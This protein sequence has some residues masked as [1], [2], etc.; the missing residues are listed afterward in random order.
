MRLL[1]SAGEASGERYGAQLIEALR[2]R[3]PDLQ[4]FGVGGESMQA[5]GCDLIVQSKE[6]AV[7]G[8]TEILPRLPKIYGEFRKLVRAVDERKPQAAILIDS[9]A[10]HFKVARELHRRGIP[11]IYYVAPQLWAWRSGRVRLMRR[12]FKKAL[13]IFPF[14]EQWYRQRG[15]D[16]EFVGHPLADLQLPRISRIEFAGQYGL[17]PTRDWIALLPGSRRK[18]VRMN[19]GTM[20]K[21]ALSLQAPEALQRPFHYLIERI[22]AFAVRQLETIMAG[23]DALGVD[24]GIEQAERLWRAAPAKPEYEFL[25]PVASTLDFDWVR[26]ILGPTLVPIRL[27]RDS[28][29]TLA[30]ACAA[31]VASG[32]ATVEAAMMGTPMAVVYRVSPLTWTLGRPLVHVKNFAMVNL[33]AGKQVV[34]ELIQSD[35]TPE[36]VAAKL[37]EILPD[38]PAREKMEQDL[39]Q[40]RERLKCGR[41]SRTAA[42]RAADAVLR[43]L[44]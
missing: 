39:A 15:V 38:G 40:V 21:G 33:I 43:S 5:A 14:E 8:I 29:T 17:N 42:E 44:N 31:V 34:P 4:C 22:R 9:P 19:L 36:K 32:T 13:V 1:I 18:E 7:V 26:G 10:F 2:R 11:A 30:H 6:L 35:F 20:V 25:L 37:R 3:V 41:D 23:E 16:A 12:Y 27:V 24:A 28:S